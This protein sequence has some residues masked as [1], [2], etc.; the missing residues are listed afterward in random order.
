VILYLRHLHAI[1]KYNYH[2]DDYK[3]FKKAK[4]ELNK[5]LKELNHELNQ[6]LHKQASAIPYNKWLL[7]SSAFSLVCGVL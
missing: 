5:S 2:G 1:K 4:E 6:L 3:E 7:S